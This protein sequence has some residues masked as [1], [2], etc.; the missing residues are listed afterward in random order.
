MHRIVK[1]ALQ[2][3]SEDRIGMVDYALES[4]GV[5]A[6]AFTTSLYPGPYTGYAPGLPGGTVLTKHTRLET[7]TN[8]TPIQGRDGRGSHEP[9]WTSAWEWLCE[10]GV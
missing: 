4:G 8:Q 3:Y 10:T 7:S 1:Q 5:C 2:R 6:A 9:E